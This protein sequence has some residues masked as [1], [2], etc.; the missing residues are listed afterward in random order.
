MTKYIYTIF[1][2]VLSIYL[3]T[4][5]FFGIPWGIFEMAMWAVSQRLAECK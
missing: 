5:F 1:D 4:M 2:W 3:V